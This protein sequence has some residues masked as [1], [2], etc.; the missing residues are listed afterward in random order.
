M[1]DIVKLVPVMKNPTRYCDWFVSIPLPRNLSTLRFSMTE[2]R[3]LDTLWRNRTLCFQ[4]NNL[5]VFDA[6][7]VMFNL[8]KDRDEI[9]GWDRL[10]E[11]DLAYSSWGYFFHNL[12]FLHTMPTVEILNMT[13]TNIGVCIAN[14]TDNQIFATS[15]KLKMLLPKSAEIS[16][17][18]PK[19]FINLNHLEFLDLSCNG[20]TQIS[21]SV[22][23][24]ASLSFLNVSHNSLYQLTPK[25]TLEL[26][27]MILNYPHAVEVN[28]QQNSFICDCHSLAFI[29]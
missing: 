10:V 11:L 26:D 16:H 18:P 9:I 17:I 1:D 23:S 29:R 7:Y 2:F 13:G 28:L 6:S 8:N 5:K 25:M 4:P 24:L 19:E 27:E 12:K 20:L 3:F 21:F 14:D 15:E 22:S